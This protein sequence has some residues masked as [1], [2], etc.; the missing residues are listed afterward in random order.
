MR[1]PGVWLYGA[2]TIGLL[3]TAGFI[4]G[5]RYVLTTAIMSAGFAYAAEYLA[6]EL[7]WGRNWFDM[8]P[9][10]Q[11]VLVVCSVASALAS[12]SVLVV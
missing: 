7:E 12:F 4:F 9:T 10:I 5:E 2:L 8:A 3:A 6:Q 11:I 1:L